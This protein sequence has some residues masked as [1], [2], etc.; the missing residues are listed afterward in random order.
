MGF[1]VPCHLKADQMLSVAQLSRAALREFQFIRKDKAPEPEQWV[2]GYQTDL[3]EN[4]HSCSL[5]HSRE[6]ASE[7]Q[8]N[9]MI[10]LTV[11]NRHL[12]YDQTLS[13]F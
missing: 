3:A 4:L 2:R 13:D 5:G 9:P 10:S 6:L 8:P 11:K 12:A 7:P 1:E